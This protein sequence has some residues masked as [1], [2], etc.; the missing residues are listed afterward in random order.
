MRKNVR[1][2]KPEGGLLGPGMGDNPGA[3]TLPQ[4][5]AG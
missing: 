1:P 2:L 3:E 4:A 5:P